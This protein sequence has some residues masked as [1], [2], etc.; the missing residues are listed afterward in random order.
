MKGMFRFWVAVGLLS[1]LMGCSGKPDTARAAAPENAN[2]AAPTAPVIAAEPDKA[3]KPVENTITI[4]AGTKLHIVLIDALSTDRNHPGDRF[5]A[6]LSQPVIVDGETVLPERTKV[7]GR[8]TDVARSGRVKGRA[9]IRLVLT[10]VVRNGKRFEISTKPFVE[11]AQSTKK[12]DGAIIGG[13]TGIGA[14][15]GGIAGGGK[16]ALIGA[17]IGAGGGTGTVLATRGKELQY[18]SETRMTFTLS[19]SLVL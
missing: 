1:T 17:A 8:V 11:V 12:R 16:G 6:S 7:N 15:I 14:L 3:D 9:S 4:P 10:G 5:S 2:A 13:G 18:P 19:S